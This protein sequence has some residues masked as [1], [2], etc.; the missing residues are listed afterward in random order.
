MSKMNTAQTMM[1]TS[2]LFVFIQSRTLGMSR[3]ARLWNSR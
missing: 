2:Q 3:W 1:L